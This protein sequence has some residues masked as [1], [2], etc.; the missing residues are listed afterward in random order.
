MEGKLR[1]AMIFCNI[2][3]Y[4]IAILL[5]C[6]AI[7]CYAMLYY[8]IAMLCYAIRHVTSADL[9]LRHRAR[10]CPAAPTNEVR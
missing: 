10:I 1:D 2:L 7:L 4:D 9:E 8:D 6:Y 3:Y 5:L